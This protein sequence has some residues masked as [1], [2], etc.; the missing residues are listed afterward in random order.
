MPALVA[1]IH[2]F[3]T[4]NQDVDGLDEPGHNA[5]V[6]GGAPHYHRNSRINARGGWPNNSLTEAG[7]S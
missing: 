1:G 4:T 2:V 6:L 3:V 5:V 7:S